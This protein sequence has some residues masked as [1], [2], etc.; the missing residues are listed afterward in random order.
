VR[1]AKGRAMTNAVRAPVK[2]ATLWIRVVSRASARGIAGRMG[3]RRCAAW[4][5]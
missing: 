4:N 3:M 5:A 2:P 1:G